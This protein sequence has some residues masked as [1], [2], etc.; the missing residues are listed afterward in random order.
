M[1]YGSDGRRAS[2][3]GGG[4]AEERSQWIRALRARDEVIGAAASVSWARARARRRDETRQREDEQ[5]N[6]TQTHTQTDAAKD[7][8]ASDE[9]K[10]GAPWPDSCCEVNSSLDTY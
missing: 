3:G 9:R 1:R 7:G 8:Q 2:R 4:R 5:R 6:G 10:A